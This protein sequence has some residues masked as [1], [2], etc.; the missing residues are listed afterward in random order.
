MV[1]LVFCAVHCFSSRSS[2]PSWFNYGFKDNLCCPPVIEL[3]HNGSLAAALLGINHDANQ[4]STAVSAC[5][6]KLSLT[7]VGGLN[8]GSVLVEI[9][10]GPGLLRFDGFFHRRL[11]YQFFH[12]FFGHAKPQ[13]GKF[14]P[15]C[16]SSDDFSIKLA[17]CRQSSGS[18]AIRFVPGCR[19]CADFITRLYIF[20]GRLLNPGRLGI[21]GIW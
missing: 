19:N 18:F 3:P 16:R 10:R 1:M 13:F 11:S 17:A 7:L 12:L 4:Y 5:K 14:T 21:S 15:G 20:G 8:A 9:R 2:C 6:S